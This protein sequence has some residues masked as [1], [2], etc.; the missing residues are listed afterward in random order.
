MISLAVMAVGIVALSRR[1]PHIA[2]HLPRDSHLVGQPE[3]EPG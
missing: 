2:T 1:V 3:N